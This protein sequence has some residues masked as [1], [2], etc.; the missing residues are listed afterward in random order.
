MIWYGTE[1][2]VAVDRLRAVSLTTR[3]EIGLLRQYLA[4]RVVEADTSASD[5]ATGRPLAAFS[6]VWVSSDTPSAS[7]RLVLEDHRWRGEIDA[8]R[9]QPRLEQIRER[10]ALLGVHA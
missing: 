4:R 9:Q 10:A 1:P 5:G 2:L 7:G 8:A 6:G 3:C